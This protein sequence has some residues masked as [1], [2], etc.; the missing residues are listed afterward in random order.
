MMAFLSKCALSTT[1]RRLLG[2]GALCLFLAPSPGAAKGPLETAVDD[3]M[4]E[5]EAAE[6]AAA[7][8]VDWRAPIIAA[9]K[10]PDATPRQS[11]LAGYLLQQAGDHARACALYRRAAEAGLMLAQHSLGE[12]I[13]HGDIDGDGAEIERWYKAAMEQ[14]S[15]ASQCALGELL[16]EGRLLPRDV[17]RGLNLCR[18]AAE[19]GSLNAK[20]TMG[21]QAAAVE[22]FDLATR[23]Y[24]EAMDGGHANG[25]VKLGA[26]ILDGR[27]RAADMAELARIAEGAGAANHP[28]AIRLASD[29]Y[30]TYLFESFEQV[31]DKL[32]G[33]YGFR[34][35]YW[36]LLTYFM[37]PDEQVKD[38]ADK[39]MAVIVQTVGDAR[40]KEW[41]GRARE[42]ATG[43]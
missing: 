5:L 31:E 21:D 41:Y 11:I 12:C 22:R 2:V 10:S 15:L 6:I 16:I 3:A 17:D 8:G 14:G 9:G 27:Y 29:L 1:A 39:R 32:N 36:I 33:P 7:E 40:I 34:A 4:A 30:S 42:E 20:L 18:A 13:V 19:G 43:G 35:Y 38:L 28:V 24:R 23:W 26:L 37:H 25:A